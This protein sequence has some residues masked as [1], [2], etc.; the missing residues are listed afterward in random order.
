MSKRMLLVLAILISSLIII[1]GILM[2]QG[3]KRS[4]MVPEKREKNIFIAM[5]EVDLDKAYQFGLSDDKKNINDEYLEMQNAYRTVL[6]DYLNSQID[7][8]DFDKE[9]SNL[10]V[11]KYF[12]L[13]QKPLKEVDNCEDYFSTLSHL[14]SNYLYLRNHIFVERLSKDDFQILKDIKNGKVL[15]HQEQEEFVKRTFLQ[16]LSYYKDIKNPKAVV[17][18][19]QYSG[20][21]KSNIEQSAILFSIEY[22]EPSDYSDIAYFSDDESEKRQKELLKYDELVLK[23]ENEFTEKLGVQVRIE[24]SLYSS[25]RKT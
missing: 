10:E 23:Y 15:K 11:S 8:T 14:K 24:N 20:A 17:Q 16:V 25:I 5:K 3:N 13:L 4:S 1:G 21:I 6:F 9:I 7:F 22:R 19:R 2:L 18:Y 12:R